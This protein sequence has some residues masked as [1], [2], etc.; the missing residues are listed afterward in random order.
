MVNFSKIQSVMRLLWDKV[1]NSNPPQ[2]H[3]TEQALKRAI[4][5]TKCVEERARSVSKSL[6]EANSGMGKA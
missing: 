3:F 4:Y 2:C 6:E 5:A 1:I